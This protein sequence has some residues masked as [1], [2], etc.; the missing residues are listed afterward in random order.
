VALADPWETARQ[1]C[2]LIA[3]YI[4]AAVACGEPIVRGKVVAVTAITADFGVMPA[5]CRKVSS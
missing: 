2:D 3:R 5:S 1:H 4:C